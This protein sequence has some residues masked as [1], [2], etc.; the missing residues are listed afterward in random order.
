MLYMPID[1]EVVAQELGVEKMVPTAQTLEVWGEAQMLALAFWE[2]V[3]QE[4]RI[5]GGFRA[6]ARGNALALGGSCL[7]LDDCIDEKRCVGD[8]EKITNRSQ[9]L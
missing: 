7:I 1:G 3:V 2:A 6:L 4:E 8:F 9:L 5:S